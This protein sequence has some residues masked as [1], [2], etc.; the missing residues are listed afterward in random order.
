[1]AIP[2]YDEMYSEFLQAL[3]DEKTHPIREIRD[4]LAESLGITDDERQQLLPSNKQTVYNNRVQW[5]ASYLKQAGLV[6]SPSRGI[7]CITEAGKTAL[8]QRKNCI[9]NTYLLQFDS[10]RNFLSR[11]SEPNPDSD[12]QSLHSAP[13]SLLPISSE[14]PQDI[15]DKAYKQINS[16]LIEDLLTEVIKQSPSFFE[17]LIVK[18]LTQ[19]GYGGSLS[20]AGIVTKASGD[21]GIDGI[22]REDKLGFS[23]IYIQAKRWDRNSTVGRPEIQKF[24][25]A[26]AG[27]GATKGLFVTTAQFSREAREYAEKQHTTKI[28]LVD[29]TALAELMIEYNIGVSVETTYSIKR[30]DTDFF[31]DNIN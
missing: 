20:D 24:V 11:S 9:N 31:D 10:F 19:M 30:I 4:T 13:V 27:Q 3:S 15:L 1:M 23:R 26:L 12:T 8:S 18:L 2:K 22:I 16:A 28:V 5:T 6:E 7:Y 21:E 17:S 25:G 29:G 14:S